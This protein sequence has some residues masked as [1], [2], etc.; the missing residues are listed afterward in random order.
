MSE[1]RLLLVSIH[2]I[3]PPSPGQYRNSRLINSGKFPQRLQ[4]AAPGDNLVK[5]CIDRLL[6]LASRLEDAEVLEVCEEGKADLRFHAGDL[7][8][9]HHQ[10]QI[11]HCTY[12]ACAAV[13]NESCCLV[14]PLVVE[15]INGILERAIGASVSTA[16]WIICA[17]ETTRIV[18]ANVFAPSL[19]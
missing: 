14:D 2:R 1:R 11:L 3:C 4:R 18:N 9:P 8:F 17:R 10:S 6:L 19:E 7:Q 13:A 15:E 5:H 16:A 12:S